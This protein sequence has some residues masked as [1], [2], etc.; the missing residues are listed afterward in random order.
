MEK[1]LKEDRK[2]LEE[3]LKAK[4]TEEQSEQFQ[5]LQ[6]EL[7]E[8]SEQVKELNRSKAEIE[9]LKREK[10]ELKEAAEAEAQKK[11]NETL[12]A[13][14]EKIRKSEEEK[15]E[16]KFRELQKQLE[17]QKKMNVPLGFFWHWQI[18]SLPINGTKPLRHSCPPIESWNLFEMSTEWTISQIVVRQYADKH[19]INLS[20]QEL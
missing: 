1:Q 7:N 2:A 16:L 3:K 5:E 20:K 17:D 19:Y 14:R 15:T 4:L 18:L 8:K 9:K 6:K 12:L 13:E 11:L 10:F